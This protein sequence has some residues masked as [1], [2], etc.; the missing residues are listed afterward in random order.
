MNNLERLKELAAEA[1]RLAAK[2]RADDVHCL[3]LGESLRRS[4]AETAGWGHNPNE[5]LADL[6][7]AFLRSNIPGGGIAGRWA[8]RAAAL[9]ELKAT[10]AQLQAAR[11]ELKELLAELGRERDEKLLA[12]YDKLTATIAKVVRPFSETEESAAR[13]AQSCD[14]PQSMHK[15]LGRWHLAGDPVIDARNFLGDLGNPIRGHRLNHS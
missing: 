10:A 6:Y 9:D 5:E 13:I 12:G 1:P 3:A 2:L 14:V 11:T 8:E 7:A 4:I 15:R